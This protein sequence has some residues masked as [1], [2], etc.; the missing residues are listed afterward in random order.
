MSA[1]VLLQLFDGTS[2]VHGAWDTIDGAQ[3]WVKIFANNE[4]HDWVRSDGS[5]QCTLGRHTFIV[6]KHKFNRTSV[7]YTSVD[8]VT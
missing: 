4:P 3:E 6:S 2:C 7:Q 1:Y 8:K 5:W